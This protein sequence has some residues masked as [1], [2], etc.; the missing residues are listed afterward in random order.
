MLRLNGLAVHLNP[1]HNWVDHG[2]YQFG[3]TLFFDYYEAAGFEPLESALFLFDVKR[4]G[5]WWV[6]PA[7]PEAFGAGLSAT[8]DGRTGLQLFMARKTASSRDTAVPTQSL[9][10]RA[11]AAAAGS[12]AGLRRF[13]SRRAA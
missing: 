7:P 10:R 2:F 5:P 1:C 4:P 12:H 9:Y 13:R 11:A 8:F 3:P 6:M